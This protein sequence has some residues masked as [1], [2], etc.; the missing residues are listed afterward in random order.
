MSEAARQAAVQLFA[1][2][3]L[4]VFF[5]ILIGNLQD[6]QHRRPFWEQYV[7]SPQL[8]D[9]AI[10][11]DSDDKR[12]LRANWREG[13]PDVADLWGAPAGHSAFIMRFRGRE[14]VVIAEMSQP[15]KAMYLF[16]TATFEEKVGTL[17]GRAF[18][19]DMLRS[20][21]PAKARWVH[22][23]NWHSAFGSNLRRY[24]VQTP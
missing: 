10:A 23:G 21:P 6:Y 16:S 14:D 19:Y 18:H 3:D 7:E 22:R 20:E 13:T 2:R 1:A 15:N 24:G 11:C 9:F 8:V 5:D 12:K 4:R 17:D